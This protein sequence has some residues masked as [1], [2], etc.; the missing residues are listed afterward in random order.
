MRSLRLTGVVHVNYGNHWNSF[1]SN[2]NK[3][4]TLHKPTTQH[5]QYL[6]NKLSNTSTHQNSKTNSIPPYVVSGDVLLT[7]QYTALGLKQ[8]KVQLYEFY[9]S[10]RQRE[11]VH[12]AG[13]HLKDR[14]LSCGTWTLEVY[15]EGDHF[16]IVFPNRISS[17]VASLEIRDGRDES[18]VPMRIKAYVAAR[19]GQVL[20]HVPGKLPR[21]MFLK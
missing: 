11:S 4:N 12:V 5:A 19:K 16:P 17:P 3:L 15:A 6:Y 8:H 18:I 2:A 10:R 14:E 1:V 20:V 7:A 9:S 13:S 21:Y